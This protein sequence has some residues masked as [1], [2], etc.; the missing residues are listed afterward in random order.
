[1]QM[2]QVRPGAV[3]SPESKLRVVSFFHNAAEG[4]LAIQLLTALG[5]PNDRL[6]VTPPEQIEGGQGMVLSI[7]C[8]DERALAKAE[9]V[10]RKLGGRL[11]RQRV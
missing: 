9:D 2:P 10:C 1:M 3:Q 5:I 11:H 7:G 8:P 6:G 4:N